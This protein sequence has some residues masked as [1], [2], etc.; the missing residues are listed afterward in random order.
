M[1]VKKRI[2]LFSGA[3][4]AIVFS[5]IFSKSTVDNDFFKLVDTAIADVVSGEPGG[6]SDPGTDSSG[7]SDGCSGGSS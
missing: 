4:L 2:L 6:P 1:K 5:A 3:M 7:S